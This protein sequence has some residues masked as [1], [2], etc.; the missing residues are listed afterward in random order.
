MVIGIAAAVAIGIL[1]RSPYPGGVFG[2]PTADALRAKYHEG[3]GGMKTVADML[4]G[5]SP[6]ERAAGALANLKHKHLAAPHERALPKL[7]NAPPVSPLAAIVA[8]PAAP[9]PPVAAAPAIGTP[10]YNV[11]TTPPVVAEAPP[12]TLFPAMP[13]PP[14]GGGLIIPPVVTP[15]VP[16]SPSQP[17]PVPEPATWAMMLIGFVFIGRIFR[18][19][20]RPAFIA[21]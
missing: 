19:R 9:L 4:L 13:P 11:V 12:P 10:L 8:A 15:I 5:R 1:V 16:P 6:G 2:S 18:T 20:P 3:V 14:P 17:S 7:R 21:A